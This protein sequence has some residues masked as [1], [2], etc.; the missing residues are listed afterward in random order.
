MDNTLSPEMQQQI[1]SYC[2]TVCAMHGLDDV[3]EELQDHFEDK[4]IAYL[5]CSEKLQEQDAFLLVREHF[6]DPAAL[7]S[8]FQTV[9]VKEAGV[10]LGRRICAVFAVTLFLSAIARAMIPV[11]GV[12]IRMG[13]SPA[14]MKWLITLISV[15]YGTLIVALIPVALYLIL[16]RW[17]RR[18][19]MD[20]PVWFT[21]M[22]VPSLLRVLVALILFE[23]LVPSVNWATRSPIATDGV[24]F[25]AA[26]LIM[27]PT[28]LAFAAQ[29]GVWMWWVD[30]AP[31]TKTA[32]IAALACW[33]A[34]GVLATG[35][36]SIFPGLG[37]IITDTKDA[38][39]FGY[40]A[41]T[42]MS[43]SATHTNYILH[44][45]M[46]R[47]F[48]LGM[49]QTRGMILVGHIMAIALAL[50]AYFAVRRMADR[51]LA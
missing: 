27:I 13:Q 3:R 26:M 49:L 36:L 23:R 44:L 45:D 5:T 19:A 34:M 29:G 25:P 11:T 28:L 48:S 4:M 33:C 43:D 18:L 2:D 42:L 9:H 30:R 31:R 22:P 8:M 6:G 24:A 50:P 17:N 51:R 40:L 41:H 47:L 7:K 46:P 37:I 38:S 14:G 12:L 15:A 10:T 21:R 35:S 1:R 16:R 39:S 32:L 20:A